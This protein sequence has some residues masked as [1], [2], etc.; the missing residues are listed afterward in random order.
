MNDIEQATVRLATIA[1]L[2]R[3]R[4]LHHQ[5]YP[6]YEATDAL[7]AEENW[8]T[9]SETPGHFVYVAEMNSIVV[10]AVDVVVLANMAHR[11]Q[12]YLLVENVIVDS[13][14]RRRGLGRVLLDAAFEHARSAGCYKLQLSAEDLD[15]FTFYEAAGWQHTARTY[16]RYVAK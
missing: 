11:G 10:G 2:A 14:H 6:E 9:I 3:L 5:L 8:K 1:D 16:K 15:A 13:A 12:P 7:T 4:E